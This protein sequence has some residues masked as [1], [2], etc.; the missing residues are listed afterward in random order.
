MTAM[1]R[2]R[3]E[4]FVIENYRATHVPTGAFWRV[5]I[6]GGGPLLAV[7]STK[8]EGLN[9]NFIELQD[10]ALLLLRARYAKHNKASEIR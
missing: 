4:D 10:M 5:D 8:P 2:A 3:A 1:L 9:Y 7:R 6:N